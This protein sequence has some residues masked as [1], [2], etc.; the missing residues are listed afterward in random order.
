MI[1]NIT[2]TAT[3]LITA[4]ALSV[5]VGCKKGEE[6]RKDYERIYNCHNQSTP[7]I[8]NVSTRMVGLWWL[9]QY[10]NNISSK[11][12]IPDYD[13]FIEFK[14]DS[15]YTVSE[16][17]KEIASGTWQVKQNQNN[18]SVDLSTPTAYTYGYIYICTEG[19][20]FDNGIVDGTT[21]YFSKI[22]K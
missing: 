5:S 13:V 2:I 6:S 18:Y 16:D 10:D 12:T 20:I 1:K 8:E 3:L 15:T 21:N 14:A 7:T 22:Y 4:F 17:G 9:Y 19:L 11:A